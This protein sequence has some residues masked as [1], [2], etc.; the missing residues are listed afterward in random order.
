MMSK[1]CLW[2]NKS[3]SIF[4]RKKMDPNNMNAAG[5]PNTPNQPVDSAQP[6]GPQTVEQA[7]AEANME[8]ASGVPMGAPA[9]KSSKGMIYGMIIFMI[10]AIGGIGFGVWAM[11]DGNMQKANLEKQISDLRA[12]NNQLQEQIAE[13]GN[14]GDDG[15]TNALPKNPV[16]PPEDNNELVSFFYQFNSADSDFNPASLEVSIA[17][18]VISS[19]IFNNSNCSVNGISGKIYKMA[20]LVRGQAPGDERLA[21][22]MEDGSVYYVSTYDQNDDGSFTAKK[23]AID[24]FVKDIIKTSIHMKEGGGYLDTIF[25]LG[26]GTFLRYTE[27]DL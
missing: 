5:M 18:G 16:I 26:D 21:F 1:V 15:G 22:L 11:M 19:C 2:Y 24:G 25:V 20:D 7:L 12:Q 17:D 14:G 4:E 6:I 27:V 9:K 13:G 10:L 8:V 3:I 23:L